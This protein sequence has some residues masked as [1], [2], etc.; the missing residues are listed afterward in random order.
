MRK[1]FS[2]IIGTLLGGLVGATLALIFAPASGSELREEL[3]MR[4][5]AFGA[6]VRR[7]IE[8]KRLELQDRI[9]ILRSGQSK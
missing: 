7:A 6:E 4:F 2:F 8:N 1:M 3:R 5:N 9:E